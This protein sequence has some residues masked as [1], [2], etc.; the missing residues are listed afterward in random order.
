MFARGQV[1][2]RLFFHIKFYTRSDIDE[3]LV[4]FLRVIETRPQLIVRTANESDSF[5]YY[6]LGVLL[7]S[8]PEIAQSSV[9]PPGLLISQS[10]V[11]ITVV[12]VRIQKVS[13]SLS[14]MTPSNKATIGFT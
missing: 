1:L 9:F 6:E 8:P 13:G 2:C 12:P 11:R 7:D 5:R 14:I 4:N 10:E 3:E